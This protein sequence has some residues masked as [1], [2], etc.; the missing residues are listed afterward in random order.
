M[1]VDVETFLLNSCR[2]AEAEDLVETLEDYEAHECGPAA[3]D[4]YTENLCAEE[5]P[6]M[7][8]E[9]TLR[10]GEQTSKDCAERATDTVDRACADRV[11][12]MELAVDELNCIDHYGTTNETD[13]DSASGRNHVATSGDADET[14]QDTVEGEGERWLT[15]LEPADND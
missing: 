5:V 14:S 12:N 6:S 4:E 15:I 8:V 9:E 1:L 10:G 11:V 2:N 7:T 3:N 13:D